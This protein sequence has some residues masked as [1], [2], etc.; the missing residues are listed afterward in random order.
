MDTEK[1]LNEAAQFVND[2][3]GMFTEAEQWTSS[4]EQLNEAWEL[5][6]V[7]RDWKRIL[8][9]AS[10]CSNDLLIAR[11]V[12]YVGSYTG[13]THPSN[14]IILNALEE[15]RKAAQE[16]KHNIIP[17]DL[18]TLLVAVERYKVSRGT[19]KRNIEDGILKSYRLEKA[20]KNSPHIVSEKEVASRYPQR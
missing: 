11:Y 19:L 12:L 8:L 1:V 13:S 16:N 4:F 18:I 14:L 17:N 6:S 3:P 7:S 9:I 15:G 5:A 2:N 20:A 10:R